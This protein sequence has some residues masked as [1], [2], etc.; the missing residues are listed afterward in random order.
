[1]NNKIVADG[2]R[3][4]WLGQKALAS[5]SVEEKYAA[6]LAK[7]NPDEKEKIRKRMA[8]ESA[9]REKVQNH[10]PSSSTLW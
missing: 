1:M 8:E 4:L 10:K 5:E 2:P 9:R 6:E 3:R 7:A